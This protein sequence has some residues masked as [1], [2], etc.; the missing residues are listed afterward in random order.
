MGWFLNGVLFERYTTFPLS[1]IFLFY[2]CY[3]DIKLKMSMPILKT[4]RAFLF[5]NWMCCV[6]RYF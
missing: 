2:L 1:L 5:Q 3:S 6:C 4:E